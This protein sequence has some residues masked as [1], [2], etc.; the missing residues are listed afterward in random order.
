MLMSRNLDLRS[1]SVIHS[2]IHSFIYLFIYLFIYSFIHSFIS[3]FIHS[4]IH[5]SIHSFIHSSSHSSIHS[6]IHSFIQPFIHA[7]ILESYLSHRQ[8]ASTL[9][10]SQPSHLTT[11]KDFT[12]MLNLEGWAIRIV[13][14][15]Y[16]FLSR[17]VLDEHSHSTVQLMLLNLQYT[18][19]QYYHWASI[20]TNIT[21]Q[22]SR[23]CSPVMSPMIARCR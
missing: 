16:Q 8:E 7:F 5:S 1:H 21:L 18:E 2:F 6:Y 13:R 3:P 9:R 20:A 14:S 22:K 23:S 4:F 12:E 15:F 11:K 19:V 10:R 17:L